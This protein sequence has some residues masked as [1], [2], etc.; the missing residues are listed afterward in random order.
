MKNNANTKLISTAKTLRKGMTD[1]ER[2]LW[3]RLRGELL[4]V[5]FRRQHPFESFVLDFV[6]LERKLVIEV[7]GS[8]HLEDVKYDE[9]RSDRLKLAGFTVLRFWN[10]QVLE[11]IDSV[12][13]VIWNHLKSCKS[14][15]DS[16]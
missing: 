13:E 8:Q 15:R 6:C 4:G 12:M 7:D 1:A 2:K 11:E 14:E 5:K 10:N 16:P 9:F 3:Q